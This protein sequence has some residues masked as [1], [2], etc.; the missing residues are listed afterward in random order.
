MER[1]EVENCISTAI[2]NS[3]SSLSFAKVT[4]IYNVTPADIREFAKKSCDGAK[5]DNAACLAMA[6]RC[7]LCALMYRCIDSLRENSADE[8]FGVAECANLVYLFSNFEI[9]YNVVSAPLSSQSSPFLHSLAS[10]SITLIR[11]KSREDIY[12]SLAQKAEEAWIV[13]CNLNH[14]EM[15]HTLVDLYNKRHEDMKLKCASTFKNV[16]L[17]P[18]AEYYGTKKGIKGYTRHRDNRCGHSCKFRDGIDCPSPEE[19][20][21]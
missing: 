14:A 15:C 20:P 6:M 9:L 4:D 11:A 13:G 18:I 8:S 12:Y 10:A 3:E 1:A 2:E 16:I 17:A 5:S 7:L 21:I 19:C